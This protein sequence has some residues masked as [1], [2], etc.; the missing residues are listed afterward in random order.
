M[1]EAITALC[2]FGNLFGSLEPGKNREFGDLM[3]T[4]QETL[5]KA[6]IVLAEKYGIDC[7]EIA[8]RDLSNGTESPTD[9]DRKV[10]LAG[11]FI[12]QL[13]RDS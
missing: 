3:L 13:N 4:V 2:R 11:H 8:D 6:A 5:G 10:L 7:G 12:G 9:H 1:E